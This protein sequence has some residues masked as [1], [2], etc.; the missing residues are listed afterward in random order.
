MQDKIGA[1][2]QVSFV[3]NGVPLNR[4]PTATCPKCGVDRLKAPCPDQNNANA[5]CPMVG[6][7]Q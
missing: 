3:L 4:P 1:S 7:A 5:G 6:P 2:D